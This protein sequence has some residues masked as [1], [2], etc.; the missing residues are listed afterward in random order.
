MAGIFLAS[1]ALASI[2]IICLKEHFSCGAQNPKKNWIL[3]ASFPFC[4]AYF[5]SLRK[6]VLQQSDRQM[7]NQ[8]NGM[9]LK[10]ANMEIVRK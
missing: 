8:G 10:N 9:M 4:A 6:G 7:E 2:G 1:P 3:G 5:I